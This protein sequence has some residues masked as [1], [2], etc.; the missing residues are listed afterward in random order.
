M[1]GSDGKKEVQKAGRG[2]TGSELTATSA[3]ADG[4]HRSS[5]ISTSTR[6]PARRDCPRAGLLFRSSFRKNRIM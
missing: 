5:R 4:W 3:S 6:R 1:H 2:G